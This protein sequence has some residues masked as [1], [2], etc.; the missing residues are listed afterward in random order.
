MIAIVEAKNEN[1]KR[2][3]GQ[4]IAEMLAAQLFNQQRYNPLKTILCAVTTGNQWKFLSLSESTVSID[5]D[6]YYINQVERIVGVLL[7]MLTHAN[8]A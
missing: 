8:Q 5:C 3:I 1:I 6:D 4:C 7:A 2:G